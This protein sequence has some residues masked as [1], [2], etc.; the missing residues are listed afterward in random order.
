MFTS[1][2][3]RQ[4]TADK[5]THGGVDASLL[6]QH[7]D[8]HLDSAESLR[9]AG[10]VRLYAISFVDEALHNLG[11]L[12]FIALHLFSTCGR[13]S[14]TVVELLRIIEKLEEIHIEVQ[15]TI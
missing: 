4:G 7:L 5:S 6:A 15:G 3:T 8:R 2:L 10:R 1:Y 14:S 9:T 11:T 13:H 12:A